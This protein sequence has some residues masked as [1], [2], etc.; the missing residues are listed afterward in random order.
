MKSI[1]KVLIVSIIAF[2]FNACG[3]SDSNYVYDSNYVQPTP[4]N[5]QIRGIVVDGY[6]E[7]ATVC[8]DIDNDAVCDSTEQSSTTASN[9]S[10]GFDKPSLFEN[11]LV[12][13]LAYGG[14]DTSTDKSFHETFQTILETSTL[15]ENETYIMSPL[16]DLVA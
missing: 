7:N 11:S 1:I 6:I 15:D 16:T 2:V 13:I 5:E 3:E 8:L 12:T 9:G 10:F 4:T 14:T